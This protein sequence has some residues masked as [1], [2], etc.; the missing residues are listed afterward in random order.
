MINFDD[1]F[2]MSMEREFGMAEHVPPVLVGFGNWVDIDHGA[3]REAGRDV[4][5]D[6][7]FVR[8]AVPGDRLSMVFQPATDDHKRRFPKA[9]AAFESRSSDDASLRGTPIQMWPPISRAMAMTLRAAHIHTVEAFAAVHDGNIDFLGMNAREMRDKARIWLEQAATNAETMRLAKEKE[10]LQGQLAAMSAQILALQN[11]QAPITHGGGGGD[12]AP[13]DSG[14]LMAEMAA[15][16]E[17]M[18][19]LRAAANQPAPPAPERRKPGPRPRV[20]ETQGA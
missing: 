17:E 15:L 3:T 5:H 7:V 10:E 14:S 16:R 12:P 11:A 19:A 6:K 13:N 8:I 18:A 9:W 2:P 4:Y 20:R 1:E